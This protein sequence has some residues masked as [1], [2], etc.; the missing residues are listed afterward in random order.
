M[1]KSYLIQYWHLSKS[2]FLNTSYKIIV[3]TAA[4]MLLLGR[5]LGVEIEVLIFILTPIG[6]MVDL[7]SNRYVISYSLP[8]SIRSR[9]HMLYYLTI[10]H[11]LIAILCAHLSYRLGN[12]QR[13]FICD[14]M[15]FLADML[16]S[17]IYYCCFCSQEFKKDVLDEDRNQLIYQ[18]MIGAVVGLGVAVRIKYGLIGPVGVLVHSIPKMIQIVLVV[19]LSIVTYIVVKKSMIELESVVRSRR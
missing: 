12:I 5:F 8:I 14:Y 13:S 19:G 18:C 4:F 7:D 1:I 3:L 16:G 11:A 10:F 6:L 17:S 2:G 15:I 9:L